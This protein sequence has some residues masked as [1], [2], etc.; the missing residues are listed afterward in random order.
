MKVQ[1]ICSALITA[2]TLVTSSFAAAPSP[3]FEALEAELN[4]IGLKSKNDICYRQEQTGT[5]TECNT[6]GSDRVCHDE[7]RRECEDTTRRECEDTTRRECTDTTRRECTDTTRRECTD[8]TR[9]ECTD[10]TRRECSNTTRRECRNESERVC[11]SVNRRECSNQQVCRNVPDEV[12]RTDANGNRVCQTVQ[13]RVCENEQVCRDVPDQVCRNVD[14]Q[15]CRDVPHQECRD[16]P[17]Q[18][19]R[20]VPD[21]VCRNVP[22][23][24]CRNVPDQ[25]C[26]NVPDQVCRNVPDQIC[27]N[28]TERVCRDVPRNSCYEVPVYEQVPYECEDNTNLPRPTLSNVTI[29][30]NGQRLQAAKTYMQQGRLLLPIRALFEALGAR[31]D[32][33]AATKKITA[34]YQGR[35]VVMTVGSTAASVDGRSVKVDVPPINIG[36]SVYIPLRFAGESLGAT[37]DYNAASRTVTVRN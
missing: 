2:M 9:R 28:T 19:C 5:R 27:R 15:V 16:V 8:T 32:Y 4:N 36:G 37:V 17:D 33:A 14:R 7:P 22:D 1:G 21:Q 26:R 29:I 12:C 31:V 10:T 18:V 24:V 11:E 6:S 35:T 13:R 30:V 20:N 3:A 25:V 23:Q 34:T